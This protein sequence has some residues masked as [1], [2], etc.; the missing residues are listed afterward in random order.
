MSYAARF[1]NLRGVTLDSSVEQAESPDIRFISEGSPIGLEVTEFFFPAV[2]PDIP[3]YLPLLQNKTVYEAWQ[4]FRDRGGPPLYVAFE[5][6]EDSRRCGPRT[7]KEKRA[8][9]ERLCEIVTLNGVPSARDSRPIDISSVV[10]QVDC[11]W[12]EPSLDGIDELWSVPRATMGRTVESAH[13]QECLD[14]KKDK[15][16]RYA[17]GFHKVW[18]LVVNDWPM[19]HAACAI[20]AEACL[21]VYSFPFDRAFWMDLDGDLV[22]LR[23]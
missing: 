12:I 6:S 8:L 7:A 22:E 3:A 5:F 14:R 16:E 17:H 11:Y 20:S 9:A 1:L 21:S 15:Y 2:D 18:L 4:K 13:V 19:Q 23:K 10:P